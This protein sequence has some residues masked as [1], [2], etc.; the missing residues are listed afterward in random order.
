[1]FARAHGSFVPFPAPTTAVPAWVR[2]SL[3]ATVAG[4]GLYLVP[5]PTPSGIAAYEGEWVE[6]ARTGRGTSKGAD[7]HLEVRPPPAL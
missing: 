5:K 4:W 6:D 2:L 3:C 7:G 1:M